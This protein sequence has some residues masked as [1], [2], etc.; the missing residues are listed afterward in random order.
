MHAYFP[1]RSLSLSLTL[2]LA[3]YAYINMQSLEFSKNPLVK[4]ECLT[5]RALARQ[6]RYSEERTYNERNIF[7]SCKVSHQDW[8]NC[9][10]KVSVQTTSVHIYL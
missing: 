10:R 6:H 3:R 2:S 9:A 5:I 7:I 4:R 8:Q 1:G